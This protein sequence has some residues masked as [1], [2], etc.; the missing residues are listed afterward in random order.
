[1]AQQLYE[2]VEIEGLG[3]LGLITYMRTDSQNISQDALHAVRGY[4]GENFG[5]RYLPESPNFYA[6][7]Q[8]RR[9][10]MRRCVRR[11]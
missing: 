9:K 11:M 5:D 8:G 2:G 1:M 6:S 7:K 4:I 10:L 3:A